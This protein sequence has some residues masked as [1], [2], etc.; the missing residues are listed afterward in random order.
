M[1]TSTYECGGFLNFIVENYEQLPRVS[2]FVHGNPI[3]TEENGNLHGDPHIFATMRH[4]DT[5]P[6][7]V[8]RKQLRKHFLVMKGAL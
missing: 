7:K 1:R 4:I 3:G 8:L 2:V 6:S 5:D